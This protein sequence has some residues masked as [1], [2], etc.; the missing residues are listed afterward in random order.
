MQRIFQKGLWIDI[1]I[2]RKALNWQIR[3][4][5]N[6]FLLIL[7]ACNFPCLRQRGEGINYAPGIADGFYRI[8]PE[9]VPLVASARGK[10]RAF[11]RKTFFWR[12]QCTGIFLFSLPGFY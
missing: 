12:F 5:H 1:C 9:F 6:P 2:A 3:I 11:K 7:L 4:G 8:L 10:Y